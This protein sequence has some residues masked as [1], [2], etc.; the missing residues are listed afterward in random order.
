MR[1]IHSTIT[2]RRKR[3][4][5]E[6]VTSTSL[7]VSLTLAR[8]CRNSSFDSLCKQGRPCPSLAKHTL[9][10]KGR[11]RKKRRRRRWKKG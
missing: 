7:M 4:E 3:R 1:F 8:S 6:E 2:R 10:I 9:T 5:E 11:R